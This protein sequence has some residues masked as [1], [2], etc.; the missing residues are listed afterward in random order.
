MIIWNCGRDRRSKRMTVAVRMRWLMCCR[1]IS[2]DLPLRDICIDAPWSS[3]DVRFTRQN[4]QI[5][6]A[7][8]VGLYCWTRAA[9]LVGVGV[10]MRDGGESGN[11][12]QKHL[13]P[14]NHLFIR[15]WPNSK[16]WFLGM[17]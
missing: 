9:H 15:L 11:L 16:V 8:V 17:V 5:Y 4:I 1:K 14:N 10:H 13:K 2:S 12:H 3:A 6:G 7:H